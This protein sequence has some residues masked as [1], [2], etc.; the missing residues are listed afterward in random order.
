[1]GCDCCGMPPPPKP[2]FAA[3]CRT[4]T[5]TAYSFWCAHDGVRAFQLLLPAVCLLTATACLLL[6]ACYCQPATACLLLPA[7]CL[8]TACLPTASL[9]LPGAWVPLPTMVAL[10][11]GV[12]LLYFILFLLFCLSFLRLLLGATALSFTCLSWLK[13]CFSEGVAFY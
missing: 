3:L 6:P 10:Y 1:M 2:C 11:Q 12:L 9:L 8:L 4:C 5:R 7:V 13:A